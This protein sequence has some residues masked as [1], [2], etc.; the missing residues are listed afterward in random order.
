MTRLLNLP[1]VLACALAGHAWV[2]A[3][4]DGTCVVYCTRCCTA[5]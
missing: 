4:I 1:W 5:E 2:G 3:I